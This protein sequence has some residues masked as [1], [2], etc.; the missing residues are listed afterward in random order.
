M[1]H[2]LYWDM[3]DKR[4][5]ETVEAVKA[6]TMPPVRR[7]A[8]YVTEACNFRCAY[9]NVKQTPRTLSREQFEEVV[10]KYGD[11]AIIH[12]TGGEP[13]VVP[14]LYP[15][16]E[17]IGPWY[18]IHLNTNAYVMP[19]AYCVKRLKVSLD[20]HDRE[21]W[22][23]LV[24]RV[25]HARVVENIRRASEQTVTSITYTLTH[26][27]MYQAAEFVDFANTQFPK[28]YA[29]FFSVYKGTDPRFVLTPHDADVLFDK[30]IPVVLER[31]NLESQALLQETLDEKRRLISGVRFPENLVDEPCYLAMSERVIAVDGSEYKCSHLYRDNVHCVDG[32]RHPSC[33]YGCNRR[34]V[35]FNTCV[36]ERLRT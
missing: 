19:P 16:L 7:V 14:W 12:I 30:V 11:T 22:N 36:S 25:A 13:S 3:F 18:N 23:S 26:E 28:L 24:G 32:K 35:E 27:T 9:C 1:R 17:E 21:Y 20:S 10:R 4:L 34:L 33:A 6:G 15:Y 2:S 29:I 5:D 31:L 8:V